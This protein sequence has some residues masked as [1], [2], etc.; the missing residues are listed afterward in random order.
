MRRKEQEQKPTMLADN[1]T[2][3]ASQTHVAHQ[4]QP[5][6]QTQ[7]ASQT[8]PVSQTRT[9]SRA[10]TAHQTQS[11]DKAKSMI[12]AARKRLFNS[13][14]QKRTRPGTY[15]LRAL[16]LVLALTVI[17]KC[18]PLLPS[19]VFPLVFL[20]YAAPAT[21]GSVYGTVVNR[22]FKQ[23]RFTPTGSL[24]DRNRKWLLWMAVFFI[25]SLL[26][27]LLF[28]L[29]APGWNDIEW[30]FIWIAAVAYYPIFRIAQRI[31]R[32]EF[33]QKLDKKIALTG[34]IVV[35]AVAL[36]VIYAIISAGS[37]LDAQV[38]FR[39]WLQSRT[40]P[41]EQSSCAVLS[42]L[43]KATTYSDVLVQYGLSYIA[44]ASYL[45]AFII[46][47]ILNASVFLGIVSQF[48]TCMLTW[49]EIKSVFQLL[50]V[51]RDKPNTE[52]ILKRYL[53]MLAGIVLVASA[54]FLCIE[55]G[56]SKAKETEQYTAIDSFLDDT[57]DLIVL[58]TE[59]GADEAL[60][61]AETNEQ[62]QAVRAEYKA[63]RDQLI[64]ESGGALRQ[65]IEAYY[66]SCKNNVDAYLDW[67]CG[68][69]G[70]FARFLPV[71]GKGMAIEQFSALV[72]NPVDRSSL[73][74]A[75]KD[76]VASLRSL[77]ADYSA[78][79]N[80]CNP[81]RAQD[82][83]TVDERFANVSDAPNLWPLWNSDAQSSIAEERLLGVNAHLDRDSLKATIVEYIGTEQSSLMSSADAAENTL[84]SLG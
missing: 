77:Y 8:Q 19:A 56:I 47:I 78:A 29:K 42:E 16:C 70:G 24:S 81:S 71:V 9:A 65:Q 30:A 22:S 20:L 23:I 21:I 84:D 73:E 75:Y 31:S 13:G 67:L 59:H 15:L 52:R 57:T 26:S 36:C 34:S 1:Q 54:A 10:R 37:P 62:T 69:Q 39:E 12:D 5:A 3:P 61:A 43:N 18:A 68:V 60:E 64:E 40:M 45:I 82:M 80:E 63:K 55:Y 28:V 79:I 50:P 83:A 72:I 35:T 38:D 44:N 53:A 27:G 6:S 32:K 66:Q 41:F 2:Q 58:T 49:P 51:E 4:T 48:R 46:Q 14:Q 11:S 33:A 17:G 25:L 7:S 76:Y 74:Q